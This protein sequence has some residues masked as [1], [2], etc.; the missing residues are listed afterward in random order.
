[1]TLMNRIYSP[2]PLSRCFNRRRCR[3][4]ASPR[5]PMSRRR[6]RAGAPS[7][8]TRAS[9]FAAASSSAR[10]MRSPRVGASARRARARESAPWR[11]GIVIPDSIP[12]A[13]V[14]SQSQGKPDPSPLS[15][16][17]SSSSVVGEVYS[18]AGL[19]DDEWKGLGAARECVRRSP[20]PSRCIAYKSYRPSSSVSD[21]RSPFFL[22]SRRVSHTAR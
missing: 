20:Q 22:R 13:P 16:F 3:F 6:P 10:E 2:P 7:P 14:S 19:R 21:L 8:R 11:G 1:M 15:S 5:S 4:R 9:G 18:S 17:A 12:A